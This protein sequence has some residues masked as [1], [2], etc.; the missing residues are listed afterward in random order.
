MKFINI[1]VFI[2]SLAIGIF[3]VYIGAPRPDII[4]VYP[5]PDNLQKL[6]YKDKGGNCFGFDSKQVTCPVQKKLIREYPM[7]EGSGK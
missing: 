5:N 1:P 4:Y 2:V 6:Q 7:Q 3:L